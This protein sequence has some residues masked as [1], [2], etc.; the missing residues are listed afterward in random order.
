MFE[1]TGVGTLLLSDGKYAKNKLFNDD[2]VVY[3]DT[4]DEAVEK[5]RYY[6]EHEVE[7]NKIALKGQQKTLTH[8]N[9]E[10]NAAKMYEFFRSFIYKSGQKSN[11]NVF[12][13]QSH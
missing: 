1:A 12:I 2:E 3:Y 7:R 6:L 4:V 5:A 13:N 10:I 9:Y 8:Y 11:R